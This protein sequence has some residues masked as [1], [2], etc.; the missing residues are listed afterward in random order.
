MEKMSRQGL[1]GVLTGKGVHKVRESKRRWPSFALSSHQP[2]HDSSPEL[3]PNHFPM[4]WDR[5]PNTGTCCQRT[6]SDKANGEPGERWR[7]RERRQDGGKTDREIHE[8]G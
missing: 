7:G 4:C 1:P 6:Q 2:I 8:K 3:P 5:V